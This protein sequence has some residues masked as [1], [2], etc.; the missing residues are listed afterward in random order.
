MSS[1]ARCKGCHHGSRMHANSACFLAAN[2]IGLT[3]ARTSPPS[4][5]AEV[6]GGGE[7]AGRGGAGGAGGATRA[8]TS[9]SGTRGVCRG[10]PWRAAVG[11]APRQAAAASCADPHLPAPIV[12]LH[13]RPLHLDRSTRCVETCSGLGR[14][15]PGSWQGGGGGPRAAGSCQLRLPAA[16]AEAADDLSSRSFGIL[17]TN[18]PLPLPSF[19]PSLPRR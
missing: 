18:Y 13:C 17:D 7:G 8:R 15:A 16:A 10:M 5:C 9:C 2:A 1:D 19:P 14:R 12:L 11:A 3:E 4:T 6:R